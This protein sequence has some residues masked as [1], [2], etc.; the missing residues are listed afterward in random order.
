MH[1]QVS[2]AEERES[3]ALKALLQTKQ[4][5][6]DATVAAEAVKHTVGSRRNAR[7][8]TLDMLTAKQHRLE[9]ELER[10]QQAIVEA[11]AH[12]VNQAVVIFHQQNSDESCANVQHRQQELLVADKADAAARR[13]TAAAQHLTYIPPPGLEHGPPPAAEASACPGD[14]LDR[15]AHPLQLLSPLSADSVESGSLLGTE[16]CSSALWEMVHLSHA[17]RSRHDSAT[18]FAARKLALHALMQWRQVS[19]DTLQ[20]AELAGDLERRN[21]QRRVLLNWQRSVSELRVWR[22]Q[23]WCIAVRQQNRLAMARALY[24]WQVFAV[25]Q[26]ELLHRF[27]TIRCAHARRMQQTALSELWLHAACKRRARALVCTALMLTMRRWFRGWRVVVLQAQ[28]M[29]GK[30]LLL[31][32]TCAQRKLRQVLRTWQGVVVIKRN[33]R[34]LQQKLTR[35]HIQRCMGATMQMWWE[36]CQ[37]ISLLRRVFGHAERAWERALQVWDSLFVSLGGYWPGNIDMKPVQP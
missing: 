6:M 5:A 3:L 15:V 31:F 16:D 37:R 2:E 19:R 14:A 27:L 11:P 34:L 24:G 28:D 1:V 8:L 30:A 10:L 7:L 13:E 29:R 17:P 21:C 32:A 20:L 26:H 4:L 12:V 22:E 9:V 36:R 35:M 25:Q 33:R 18:Q 23:Q